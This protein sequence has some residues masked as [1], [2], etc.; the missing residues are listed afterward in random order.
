MKNDPLRI[1]KF[2]VGVI[3]VYVNRT[4]AARSAP[5][6]PVKT[7]ELLKIAQKQKCDEIY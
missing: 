3:F 5:S 2:F 7:S 1:I 4:N 6:L